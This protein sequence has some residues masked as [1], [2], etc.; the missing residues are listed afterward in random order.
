MFLE[1]ALTQARKY[2]EMR[3]DPA[4]G[5]VV[6]VNS[7]GP[8]VKQEE[9]VYMDHDDWLEKCD[10][11]VQLYHALDQIVA[12]CQPL[13]LAIATSDGDGEVRLSD[14]DV[15]RFMHSFEVVSVDVH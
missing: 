7:P 14:E 2:V 12:A 3:V 13:V 4:V 1:A 9:R 15:E 10:E 11:T 6:L 5:L 8:G